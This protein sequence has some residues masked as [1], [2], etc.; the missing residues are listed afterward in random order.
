M[1]RMTVLIDIDAMIRKVLKTRLSRRSVVFNNYI[2][3]HFDGTYVLKLSIT[4]TNACASK[5]VYE[6]A[7][8]T[9]LGMWYER[10]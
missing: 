6:F 3:K 4:R 10:I 9:D 7:S 8:E 2:K 1:I 5:R